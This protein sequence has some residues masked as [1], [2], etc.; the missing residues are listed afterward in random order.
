MMPV[1]LAEGY[2]SV[3]LRGDVVLFALL[4]IVAVVLGGV[5]LV[6]YLVFA[7]LKRRQTDRAEKA[8]MKKFFDERSSQG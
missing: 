3:Q 7:V 1:I 8:A 6:V 2:R 4:A 5:G